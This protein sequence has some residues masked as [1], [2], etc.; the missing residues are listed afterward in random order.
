M[1]KHNGD[2]PRSESSVSANRLLRTLKIIGFCSRN[3]CVSVLI[4]SSGTFALSFIGHL[5]AEG[6]VSTISLSIER[7]PFYVGEAGWLDLDTEI[8]WDIATI[9]NEDYPLSAT[10]VG[11]AIR[12][13][14]TNSD[15][16]TAAG[17]EFKRVETTT[18]PPDILFVLLSDEMIKKIC[19]SRAAGCAKS[20]DAY[21]YLRIFPVE[22]KM[23]VRRFNAPN[24]E[25][26]CYVLLE[27]Y[28][29]DPYFFV[30]AVNHEIGH[31]LGLK[32][33][34]NEADVMSI[35]SAGTAFPSPAEIELILG[36]VKK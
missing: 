6:K 1:E 35:G 21:T 15:G 3:L 28:Q 2:E 10:D 34:S 27:Q 32:H 12:H 30:Y 18:Q 36:K 4:C 9:T 31:C 22:L 23:P 19:G 25:A 16:W 5:A 29:P 13:V 26:S 14:L 24:A 20:N 11:F 8:T 7:P 17:L 33:S